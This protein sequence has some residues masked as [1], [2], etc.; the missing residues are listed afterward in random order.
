[1]SR[2]S[3]SLAVLLFLHALAIPLALHVFA[4]T[5][6]H[7]TIVGS[8][9]QFASRSQS[10]DS[11]RPMRAAKS[12]VLQSPGHDIYEEV[13]FH[14]HLKFQYPPTALLFTGDTSSDR[15][16]AISWLAVWITAG[17]AAALFLVS[18][19]DR[20]L[21]THDPRDRILAALAAFGLSLTFYPL[22]KGYTLGQIQV[23][24]DAVFALGACAWW[25][26]R[27]FVAGLAVGVA[28][29]IK[30]TLAP[31]ALWAVLRREWRFAAGIAVVAAGGLAIAIAS[32]GLSSH[33]SYLRVLSFIAAR[34]EAYYPNQSVNGL[35][36]RWFQNGSILEF[37][38]FAFSPYHPWVAWGTAIT[39]V[40]LLAAACSL[41]FVRRALDHRLEFAIAAVTA[42]I[43]SPIVWEHH[44]GIVLPI[45]A[46]A[47]PLVVAASPAGRATPFLLALVFVLI[48]Q[49]FEATQRFAYTSWNALESYTLFGALLFLSLL[50]GSLVPARETSGV[51]W[52]RM[53]PTADPLR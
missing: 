39:T 42:T 51:T 2:L 26:G 43:A 32:F 19:I 33:L 3:I 35:L 13:F 7:L 53:L 34:G 28:C 24:V 16:N 21:V 6:R 1:M 48:G 25:A 36:N 11:W 30:P 20:K 10:D 44:Y 18:A 8:A 41:P 38:D 15:L 22:L 12:Y 14:R 45:L 29:L 4:G 49:Y 50:Y 46:M 9:E 40:A 5:P 37:D 31:L 23:W 17:L 27:R 47:M 52:T